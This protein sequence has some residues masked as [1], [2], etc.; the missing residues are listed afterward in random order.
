MPQANDEL[1]ARWT[2]DKALELL[3]DNFTWP[4][5]GFLP[6][7]IGYEAT[8]EEESAMDYMWLEWDYADHKLYLEWKTKRY[9]NEHEDG[10]Q[11]T[12]GAAY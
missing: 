11:G 1:R 3:K 5:G 4:N 7:Q 10:P 2:D 12:S 6:K 9:A 8:D